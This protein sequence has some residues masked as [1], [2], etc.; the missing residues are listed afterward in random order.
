MKN[1][2]K[3]TLG[4]IAGSMIITSCSKQNDELN[5]SSTV[6]LK[7]NQ[8]FSYDLNSN[9]AEVVKVPLHAQM[10]E[11]K[12]LYPN[13]EAVCYAYQPDSFYNG[14]DTVEISVFEEKAN[15]KRKNEHIVQ[16]VFKVKHM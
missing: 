5:T 16:L 13:S 1:A 4:L 3:I 10:S 15:G 7:P 8:E 14:M 2:K 11:I 12:E 6:L 9:G